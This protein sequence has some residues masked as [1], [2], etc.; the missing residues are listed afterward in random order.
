MSNSK[1]LLAILA[2]I[3]SSIHAGQIPTDIEEKIQAD[4]REYREKE[5]FPS[6]GGIIV[7]KS[8]ESNIPV[9]LNV[10]WLKARKEQQK[11]GYVKTYSDRAKELISLDDA[12]SFKYEASNKNTDKKS[13]IFRENLSEIEVGYDFIT[14]SGGD[15]DLIYGFAGENTFKNGWTGVIEF[16]KA[17]GI[18]NCAFSEHS[19]KLTH[20]AVRVDETFVTYSVNEKVSVVEVEGNKSSGYV[21][22][23][24]WFDNNYFRDLE[25][26]NPIYSESLMKNV[27][28]LANKIDKR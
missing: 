5:G 2:L 7:V 12:V 20:E 26:A 19:V 28:L 15:L 25:C 17:K 4:M 16:F 6:D 10:K 22:K 1:T 9:R 8:S 23:V 11:N 14:F 24:E 3:S 21:Y 18:G 27:I 13:S